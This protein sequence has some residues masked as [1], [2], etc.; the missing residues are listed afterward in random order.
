L[1]NSIRNKLLLIS[2]ASIVLILASALFGFWTAYSSV[3]KF[4]GEVAARNANEQLVRLIQLNFKKQ[5]QEWK[6][7]LLRG[8]DPEML[9]KYWGNFEKQE[10]LVEEDGKKLAARLGD[11]PHAQDLV[12][13]FLAAHH[14]MG[15]NYR[16]GLQAFKDAN[17]DSHAGDAAVKGM[18]RPPTELLSQAADDVAA[19]AAQSAEQ[20]AGGAKKGVEVSI[21]AMLVSMLLGFVLFI[22]LVDKNI[23]LPAGLV[24]KD[25]E[26][27]AEGDFSVPVRQ[28]SR[29]E[30]GKIA[31][32]AEN[33]RVS[34][35][36]IIGDV[37][38]AAGQVS[39]SSAVLSDS[40]AQVTQA[41]HQQVEAAS[42]VAAAIE[43]MSVSV[44]S[45]AES[46]DE[47]KNL[48]A[49]SLEQ[50]R[51]G[52]VTL[53]EMVAE[54][55]SL[56]MAMEQIRATVSEFVRDVGSI[57][58]MTQEVKEIADQTNLLA[59]N[60]AIEAARA[61]EQGRGFA[62]V[63]DEVR[64]LAEKS[65]LSAGEIDAVTQ[66][67]NSQSGE[68]ENAISNGETILAKGNDA[69]ENMAMAI[70][71]SASSVTH[72][73]QGME[74]IANSVIEQKTVSQDIARHIEEIAQ[75]EE[76][77]SLKVAQVSEE[78]QRFSELAATLQ[79]GMARF[80]I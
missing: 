54:F 56:E 15:D 31:S 11:T 49:A 43:E 69:L 14:E 76:E 8:A 25:L 57:A 12:Q 27:M 62:V 50:T 16:K 60:A 24:V 46:A 2:G 30:L 26:R 32:S 34:L 66:K 79:A 77:N 13:K 74:N 4:T 48:S 70:A 7:V 44:A 20:A 29:D 80:K 58:N 52:N 78:A 53:S 45:V 35:S 59:L 37:A 51:Q 47:V 65:A 9:N 71:E 41:S 17:F 10:Q 39:S 55:S 1:G 19:A 40:A 5:V 73:S 64:K 38:H 72:A 21:V 33:I 68:M 28:M 63:A 3:Q 23:V 42:A 6:D 36:K 75:M 61:G 18:D 22:W 67:L